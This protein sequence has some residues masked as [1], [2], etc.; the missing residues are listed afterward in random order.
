[1][2]DVHWRNTGRYQDWKREKGPGMTSCHHACGTFADELMRPCSSVSPAKHY[3]FHLIT[4]P[5]HALI[6]LYSSDQCNSSPAIT[7]H[8]P[9][10]ARAVR[11]SSFLT[12]SPHAA[13][14]T[15]SISSSMAWPSPQTFPTLHPPEGCRQTWDTCAEPRMNLGTRMRYNVDRKLL[16]MMVLSDARPTRILLCSTTAASWLA[17]CNFAITSRT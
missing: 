17:G 1:M 4:G 14:I 13:N 2:A 5:G 16:G 10:Q 15:P 3:F 7:R 11:L 8:T 6:T 12:E 9:D